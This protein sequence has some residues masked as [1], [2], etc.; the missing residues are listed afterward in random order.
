MCTEEASLYISFISF[1][2]PPPPF[3]YTPLCQKLPSASAQGWQETALSWKYCCLKTRALSLE[4]IPYS[5]KLSREKTITNFEVW[6]PSAKVFSAKFGACRTHLWLVSS[7][8]WKFSPQNSHF[9][10]I[11]ESFLP[12]KFTAIRYPASCSIHGLC[13]LKVIEAMF[14]FH[15]FRLVC[16][17]FN[18]THVAQMPKSG[19][20]MSTDGQ[21]DHITPGMG[22][23]MNTYV[24]ALLSQG[25]TSLMQAKWDQ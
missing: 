21:T 8:P 24:H 12:R 25:R 20:L 18:Y 19:N 15:H 7:N 2:I 22:R 16:G 13:Y 6:E 17:T 4:H 23:V 9:L 11:R 5:G 1:S 3:P 10:R 14:F